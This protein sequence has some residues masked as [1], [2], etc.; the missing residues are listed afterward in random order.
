M[1]CDTSPGEVLNPS[2]M[3]SEQV[4]S[5]SCGFR[6]STSIQPSTGQCEHWLSNAIQN[7]LRAFDKPFASGVS[8][9]LNEQKQAN[10]DS[11]NEQEH[12]K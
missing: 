12:G 5:P 6:Y 10:R 11:A 4:R 7:L 9:L 8:R 3:H 1:R 2:L